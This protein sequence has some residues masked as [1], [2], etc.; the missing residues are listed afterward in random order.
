MFACESTPFAVKL[1]LKLIKTKVKQA[2]PLFYK[3]AETK[4]YS[5]QKLK[6]NFKRVNSDY[7]FTFSI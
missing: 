4:L 7:N 2:N 3:P 6:T 5:Q 1:A